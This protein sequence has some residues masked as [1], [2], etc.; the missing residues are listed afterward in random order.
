MAD[1]DKLLVFAAVDLPFAV[2]SEAK[3]QNTMEFLAIIFGLLQSPWRQHE[4]I[5]LGRKRQS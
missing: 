2:N 1:D 4:F 3:R 5:S